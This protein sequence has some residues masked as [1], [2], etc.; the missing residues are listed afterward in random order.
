M[1]ET[2]RRRAF[3]QT[4]MQTAGLVVLLD[5]A[6]GSVTFTEAE[7]QAVVAKHGGTTRL[8]IH[9]EVVGTPGE[10]PDTVRLQLISKE[11]GNADL[12]S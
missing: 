9:M 12:V 5:R 2:A 7:Y 3:N 4:A 11:A 6:G 10:Q 1:D 8:S